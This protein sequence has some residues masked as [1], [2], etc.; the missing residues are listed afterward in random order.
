MRR[1]RRNIGK[2]WGVSDWKIYENEEADRK[3]KENRE[4]PEDFLLETIGKL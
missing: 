2:I 3:I 1:K 4:N